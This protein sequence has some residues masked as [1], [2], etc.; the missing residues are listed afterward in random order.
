MAPIPVRL[1]VVTTYQPGATWRPRTL[2]PGQALLAL[3][4]NTVAA[5]RNPAYSMPILKHTLSGAAAIRGKRG[6]A[7]AIV[8]DVLRRVALYSSPGHNL[9]F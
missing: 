7:G 9:R 4:D 6:E 3:M 2:S 8:A 1:V 5:R